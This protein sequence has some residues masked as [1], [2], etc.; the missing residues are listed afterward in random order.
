MNKIKKSIICLSF[1]LLL[2]TGIFADDQI[3]IE[4]NLFRGII[5]TSEAYPHEVIIT[6]FS[7]PFFVPDT[8][9]NTELISES[10]TSLKN[11]LNKVFQVKRIDHLIS[12]NMIWDGKKGILVE[13]I[14]LDEFSYPIHFS[15][16]IISRNS[17]NLQVEMF[18]GR[19]GDAAEGDDKLEKLL[20]T[21]IVI[22]FDKPVILGF[23]INGNTYF[24]SIYITRRSSG[25]LLSGKVIKVPSLT[26]IMMPP[27]PVYR[28]NPIYPIQ[29]RNSQIEGSVIVEVSTDTRGYVKRV[30]VLKPAHPDLDRAALLALKQW[31]YEPLSMDE[32]PVPALFAVSMDFKLRGLESIQEQRTGKDVQ[33]D[34]DRILKKCASYCE[35]LEYTALNFVCKEEITENIYRGPSTGKNTYNYDYNLKKKKDEIAESRILREEN[36]KKCY[37]MEAELKTNIFLSERA[38]FAPVELISESVQDLYD[39]E[40]E[41]EEGIFGRKACVIK[42]TPKKENDLSYGKLWIDVEDF[43]VLK[44]EMKQESLV[45][46][47][48]LKEGLKEHGIEPVL[49]TTHCY[50]IEKKGIRFPSRTDFLENYR[51]LSRFRSRETRRSRTVIEFSDYQFLILKQM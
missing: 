37:E 30:R 20:D 19:N 50:E 42:A 26:P 7:T 23:P 43:S 14:S 6:S 4:S 22:N 49:S 32:K 35:K 46:Y 15:P 34:L 5:Q 33:I 9:K 28:F 17:V 51:G 13:E 25:A 3:V 48:G 10:V 11:E 21:E 41:K 45:G 31:R 40:L 12:G 38:M 39:Y 8:S 1:F 36:G 44:I 18:K 29:C 47:A 16:E 2:S 27:R 24:L